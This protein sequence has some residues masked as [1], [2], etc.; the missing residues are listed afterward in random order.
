MKKTLVRWRL[1]LAC[2][3]FGLPIMDTETAEQEKEQ[4]CLV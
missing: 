4:H 1:S 3:R 2:Q